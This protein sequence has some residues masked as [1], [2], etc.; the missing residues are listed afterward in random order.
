MLLAQDE[1]SRTGDRAVR[2]VLE[3]VAGRSG[4]LPDEVASVDPEGARAL[5]HEDLRGR[6]EPDGEPDVVPADAEWQ[7]LRYVTED[8]PAL[9]MIWEKQPLPETLRRLDEMGI[10]TLVF[11]P[12]ANRPRQGDFLDVMQQNVQ[13][14]GRAYPLPE[15]G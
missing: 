10:G 13:D 9:W 5:L 15:Q 3:H 14:L 1:R 6:E 2:R 12:C 11:D 7:R 8:F 4:S